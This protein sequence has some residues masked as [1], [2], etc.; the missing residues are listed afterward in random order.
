MTTREL[1][2]ALALATPKQLEDAILAQTY[3]R[4][5]QIKGIAG[6]LPDELKKEIQRLSGKRRGDAWAATTTPA[7]KSE[8]GRMAAQ[9]RWKNHRR[10]IK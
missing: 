9:V 7:E 6:R 1:V 5:R 8:R 2:L 4:R 3:L 10:K